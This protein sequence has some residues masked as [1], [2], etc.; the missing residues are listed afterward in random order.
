MAIVENEPV[1]SFFL[2][3]VAIECLLSSIVIQESDVPWDVYKSF[4]G[5]NLFESLSSGE[6]SCLA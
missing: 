4:Y 5:P 3:V 1:V 2:F 6:G